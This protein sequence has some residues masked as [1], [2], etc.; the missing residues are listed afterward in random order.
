MRA[1]VYL[2]QAR[3]AEALRWAAERQLSADDELTYVREYEHITLARAL[4]AQ[5]D[6]GAARLLE[7]LL[8]GAR[9]GHR[10]GSVIEIL[11][12]QALAQQAGGDRA[13]ALA[14]LGE[15]LTMAEPEEYVRLFLDEG[16]PMAALLRQAAA[17]DYA[18]R[19]L[20]SS[21]P[22]GVLQQTGLIEALSDRE[23]DVLRLLRSELGGPEIAREL[24]VSLN[25]LRTH[26]KH[27]YAKLGVTS[28]RAAV[29]RA[30]ELD[31]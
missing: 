9:A 21:G 2:A 30:E 20:A 11:V 18:R 17:H 13:T 26:T 8:A 27:I 6:G 29:R 1:R 12:L 3:V 28:R 31:L 7:R 5:R 14:T 16:P 19:L 24:T 22:N 4:M 25:T 10:T 15:A 23:L